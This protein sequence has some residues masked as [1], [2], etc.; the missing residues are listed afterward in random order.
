MSKIGKLPIPIPSGVKVDIAGEEVKI[1]GPR[2]FLVQKLHKDMIVKIE[3]DQLTVSRPTDQGQHRALH[4]LT[5]S[6]INNM[7]I[8]VSEGYKKTLEMVGIGYRA[9]MKGK[10]L[11]LHLGFSHPM[12]LLPP[13]G[14]EI[15][16]I[17]KENKIIVSGINKQLV[18]QT[19][20]EIRKFRPPEPYKGKGIRYEGEQV[21]RKAGK[22]A[23]GTGA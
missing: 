14:I 20:A 7:V 3:N 15:E 10:L 1:T 5:R 17:P 22:A 2:G 11:E 13:E 16:I 6:L 4:G 12:L 23:A 8:G 19:A 18:G 9:E 21:R